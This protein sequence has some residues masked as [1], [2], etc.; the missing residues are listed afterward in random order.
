MAQY[1]GAMYQI[2]GKVRP[3]S[4]D[5]RLAYYHHVN[6]RLRTGVTFTMNPSRPQVVT[7]LTYRVLTDTSVFRATVG[8]DGVVGSLWEKRFSDRVAMSTSFSV[9]HVLKNYEMG[10][11][12]SFDWQKL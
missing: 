7:R 10:I 1:V 12:L 11:G 8:T 5:V 2:P 9:N 6:E 3:I 4:R